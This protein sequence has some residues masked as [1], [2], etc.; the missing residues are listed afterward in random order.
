MPK[1]PPPPDPLSLTLLWIGAAI[2]AIKAGDLPLIEGAP[3]WLASRA[4]GYVPFVLVTFY[5]VVALYRALHPA[6]ARSVTLPKVD[7]GP[8]AA[9]NAPKQDAGQIDGADILPEQIAREYLTLK[10]SRATVVQ[11][12]RFLRPYLGKWMALKLTLFDLTVY[13]DG[14]IRAQLYCTNNEGHHLSSPVFAY[15][16][17][18]WEDHLQHLKKGDELSFRGKVA[19]QGGAGSPEF[20]QAEPI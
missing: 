16:D 5:L 11:E 4:W 7:I 12:A 20:R 19:M 17:K 9:A 2:M 10:I 14:L 18:K 6:A 15:F 1:L 8:I 13:Q 3:M